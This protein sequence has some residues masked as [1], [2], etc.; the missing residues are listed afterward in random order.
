MSP[1]RFIEK[2]GGGI[3]RL[4]LDCQGWNVTIDLIPLDRDVRSEVRAS[5]GY[6]VSGIGRVEQ[7]NGKMFSLEK[8]QPVLDVLQHLLS[9]AMHRWCSPFLLVGLDRKGNKLCEQWL[10]PLYAVNA[11]I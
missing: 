5:R 9:F 1:D 3:Q 7:S 2:G 8:V 6:V 4:R 10:V 11:F